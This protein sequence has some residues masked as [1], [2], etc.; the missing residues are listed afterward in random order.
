MQNSPLP[1]SLIAFLALILSA[2]SQAP[3]TPQ[4]VSDA[5]WLAVSS[6]DVSSAVNYSTLSEP[7]QYDSFS[8][9]WSGYQISFGK[10]T[11]DGH[12]AEI[13][14]SAMHADTSQEQRSFTTYLLAQNDVWKV[15]YNLT[16]TSVQG[17][18][19]GQLLGNLSRMGD[20][21]SDQVQSSAN[22]FTEEMERMKK[23]F[24]RLSD[25]FEKD[26]RTSIEKY[27]EELKQ[28]IEELRTL[29]ERALTEQDDK[30][31]N[32]DKNALLAISEDLKGESAQLSNAD[33]VT[34]QRSN[35]N[36]LAAQEQFN[37]IDNDSLATYRKEWGDVSA[38]L[39]K[40]MRE[41][42]RDI[43]R[44]VRQQHKM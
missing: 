14:T 19:L 30:L 5:F 41:I 1:L 37:A 9:N 22:D 35:D 32:E 3:S 29:I 23:E 44:M 25:S 40:E 36:F 31:S 17:G 20:E 33:L 7:T 21:I 4:Q 2:C 28:S 34:F 38:E 10:I 12:V 42:M 6:N 11:I 13:A 8:K 43:S 15:D 24:D 18:K 27:S 16:N 26:A 39:N